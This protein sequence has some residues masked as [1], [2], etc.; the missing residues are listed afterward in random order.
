[1]NKKQTKENKLILIPK[2]EKY[3]E[4]I[5]PIIIKVTKDRKV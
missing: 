3:I 4:Y 2:A 5:L 1:M